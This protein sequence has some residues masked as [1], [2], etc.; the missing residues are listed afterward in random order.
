MWVCGKISQH[1][2]LIWIVGLIKNFTSNAK[3]ACYHVFNKIDAKL[4]PF[5]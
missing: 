2:V 3:L 5:I 1:P 4:Q